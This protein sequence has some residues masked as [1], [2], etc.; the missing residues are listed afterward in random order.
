[1]YNIIDYSYSVG[2]IANC[3]YFPEESRCLFNTPLS[4]INIF[5]HHRNF[6]RKNTYIRITNSTLEYWNP[7]L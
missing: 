7:A 6:V 4:L 5:E 1:M 2:F 3:D